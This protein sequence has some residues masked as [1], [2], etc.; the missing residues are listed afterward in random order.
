[1]NKVILL[2]GSPNIKGNTMIVLNKCADVIKANGVDA[3]V[4]SLSGMD[5]SDCMN[6]RKKDDGFAEIIEKI[7]QAQGFIVGS[8]VYWGTARAETMAA[9]QRI[10]MA[11]GNDRHFLS[12]KVGGPIAVARRGGLTSTLSEMLMFYFI[13]DM[14]VPGSTYWNIVFGRQPGDVLKD[15]EGV[16]TV[17]RFSENVAYLINKLY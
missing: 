4:V 9:L 10:A 17:Q 11:S 13:N 5:L 1:M 8:P 15:E 14:I 3:E 7:K 16:R 6:P 2:S 12:R